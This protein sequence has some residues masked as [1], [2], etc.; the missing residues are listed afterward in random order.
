MVEVISSDNTL[1]DLC[2]E[3]GARLANSIFANERAKLDMKKQEEE[4]SKKYDFSYEDDDK[5]DISIKIEDDFLDGDNDDVLIKKESDNEMDDRERILYT[6]PKR[7]NDN[8][9]D[10]GETI[11]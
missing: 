9:I 1:T 6:S 2:A 8:E 10:D 4:I 7:E 5:K 11:L 3:I